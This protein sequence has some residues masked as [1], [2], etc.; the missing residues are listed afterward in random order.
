MFDEAMF[1][2][3][4]NLEDRLKGVIHDD[5][6]QKGIAYHLTVDS[7]YT[8]ARGQ[9]D[10]G[11]SERQDSSSSP[12][13]PEKQNPGDD[14]GWWKLGRGFYHISYNESIELQ[15]KELGMIAPLPRILASGTTHQTL[16][17]AAGKEPT[18]NLLL[19]G[20]QGIDIK[21]NAR[22]SQLS[23]WRQTS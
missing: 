9:I 6:Q 14:Y 16:L 1:V 5:T 17:F 20:N 15:E 8:L 22:V 13:E 10:F 12:V 7:V 19:V 18:A 23:I 2:S 11:G 21:E 3:A 4:E